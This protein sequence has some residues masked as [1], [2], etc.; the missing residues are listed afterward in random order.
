MDPKN[1]EQC[2]EVYDRVKGDVEHALSYLLE[3]RDSDPYERPAARLLYERTRGAQA[4][5]FPLD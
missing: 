5:T 2:Q 1:R 4:P 3:K